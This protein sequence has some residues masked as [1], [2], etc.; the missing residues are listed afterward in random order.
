MADKSIPANSGEH[1]SLLRQALRAVEQMKRKLDVAESRNQQPIAIV[2]MGCRF[3]GDVHDAESFWELLRDGREAIKEV[4]LERWKIDDYYDPDPSRPGKMVTRFGG[5]LSD[6]D[7]FDAAFFGIAP[8]E[9]AMMDPQQRI[10]LEVTWQALESGCI[11]P[12]S[13]AGSKTGM[14]LGIASGDYAQMQLHAGDAGLLDVHYASG[15]SHSIASGRLSYLLGLKGPSLSIDTACS[16]SLVA[17]HLACLALR[18]GECTMAI[19]G[20]VNVTFAPETTV[21]L[22]QAHM[23][24][25][26]GRSK[27]FDDKADGFARAEGCG[28]AI[29]KRLTQAEKDGDRILAVIRGTALNQDGASSS[30][31][32]PN[33]PSQEDLMR[34][35]LENAGKSASQIGYVE[36]HGTGTSLGDPI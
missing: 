3:P 12:Q 25:P 30:L 15:N 14:Y 2:G 29:L 24:A 10:L 6:I 22:S 4:P 32:A 11:A 8:R 9:A 1:A 35:A 20:G 21:A 17:I 19:A 33:G 7:C 23:L 36:A 16:S 31:T 34:G 27:A 26:D 5:F 18:A 28:V 13:L